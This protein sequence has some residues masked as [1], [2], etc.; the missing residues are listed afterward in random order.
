MTYRSFETRPVEVC[1]S[2]AENSFFFTMHF[3]SQVLVCISQA[4]V[5]TYQ[6][7]GYKMCRVVTKFSL[8]V[9][10]F[11]C[12]LLALFVVWVDWVT[13]KALLTANVNTMNQKRQTCQTTIIAFLTRQRKPYRIASGRS[14][15]LDAATDMVKVGI[16]L[17]YDLTTHDILSP[18]Q[19]AIAPIADAWRVEKCL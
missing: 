19:A 12:L 7:L 3:A 11:G 1:V 5:C 14:F 18:L 2:S 9:N 15:G 10:G 17:A 13:V 16:V 4:L 8:Y 6:T